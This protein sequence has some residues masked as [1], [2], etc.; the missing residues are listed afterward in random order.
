MKRGDRIKVRDSEDDEWQERILLAEMGGNW[1][2]ACVNA[3]SE[4][5]YPDGG[6]GVNLWKYAEPIPETEVVPLTKE[7]FHGEPV[8]LETELYGVH[9]YSYVPVKWRYNGVLLFELGWVSW[10]ELAKNWKY[11][12]DGKWQPMNKVVEK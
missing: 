12:K 1:A 7:D 10:E 9:S 8:R 4:N 11:Y 5:L 2:V 3:F 6:Y